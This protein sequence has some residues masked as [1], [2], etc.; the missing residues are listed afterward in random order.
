MNG[1]QP[2]RRVVVVG[3]AVAGVL[4]LVGAVLVW[5]GGRDTSSST[6]P[7]E[8]TVFEG[9]AGAGSQPPGS[10]A[11]GGAVETAGFSHDE[12]G[13]A[14]VAVAYTAVAEEWLYLD[15]EQTLMAAH[16]S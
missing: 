14:A 12:Q 3:V 10:L 15:D 1:G 9:A 5:A 4:V 13:A 7:R 16:R 8:A 11:L 6:P 2:R